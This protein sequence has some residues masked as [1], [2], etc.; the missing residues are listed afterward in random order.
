MCI[1]KYYIALKILLLHLIDK[2]QYVIFSCD[3]YF[4][5]YKN[6]FLVY[7]CNIFCLY[8]I[9]LHIVLYYILSDYWYPIPSEYQYCIDI[10]S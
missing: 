2:I 8:Y 9:I 3:M 1:Y 4:R 10:K 7:F 5:N 6:S